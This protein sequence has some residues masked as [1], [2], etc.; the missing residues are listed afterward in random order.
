MFFL[1]ISGLTSLTKSAD[2]PVSV[3]FCICCLSN[4]VAG[5][6]GGFVCAVGQFGAGKDGGL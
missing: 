6:L 2:S 4:S 3:W 5:Q 1:W